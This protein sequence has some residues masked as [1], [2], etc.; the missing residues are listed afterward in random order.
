[1]SRTVKTRVKLPYNSRMAEIK[2]FEQR[3]LQP[4]ELS[5]RAKRRKKQFLYL[6]RMS[7]RV[8]STI[9]ILLNCLLFSFVTIPVYIFLLLRLVIIFRSI[10]YTETIYGLYGVPLNLRFFN[11]QNR[12]LAGCS[13]FWYVFTR[14]LGLTGPGIRS[15][16]SVN[17]EHGD[18]FL[19]NTRPGIFTLWYVRQAGG[20]A[21]GNRKKVEEEYYY[22]RCYWSDFTLI[23]KT[24]ITF[25]FSTKIELSK[26]RINLFGVTFHNLPMGEAIKIIQ[27]AINSQTKKR[28]FFVN[29]DC[30]NRTFKDQ[31]YL[32]ILQQTP[33]IFPDGIG[34]KI[35]CKMIRSPILENVNGTDMLPFLCEAAVQNRLTIYLL[36]GQPGIAERMRNNLLVKYS[37]LKIV[38]FQHGFFNHETDSK[39]V[40]DS[41]NRSHADILMVAFGVPT[42]EKWISQHFDEIKCNAILG[43]GGLFDFYSNNIRRAPKWIREIGMEWCFR[44][45]MEPR[46]M[47]KRYVIGNPL[48]LWRVLRWRR[49]AQFEQEHAKSPQQ[50]GTSSDNSDQD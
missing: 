49:K 18:A 31:E 16:D 23:L 6:L 25:F 2:A 38:G 45:A 41:I 50:E 1:M 3:F 37:R 47:F 17:R 33:D 19:F 36:G 14:K 9:E 22:G 15:Y 30:F 27:R 12:V 34:V 48:F 39:K 32:E 21:Y 40:I 24:I 46:R 26:P 5:R 42:Q 7:K 4:E 13:L 8:D 10:Y 28:F 35:A 20:I 44:L 11:F 43:V 29:P